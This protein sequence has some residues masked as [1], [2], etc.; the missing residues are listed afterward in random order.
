MRITRENTMC[1]IIDDQQKLIPSILNEQEL[2]ENTKKL[3]AGLLA[4]EIPCIVTEHYKKGLGETVP[5]LQEA[6]HMPEKQRHMIKLP[7]VLMKM[8]KLKKLLLLSTKKIF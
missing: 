4:L 6:L 3:S 5:I 7:L 2:L 1:I 8:R